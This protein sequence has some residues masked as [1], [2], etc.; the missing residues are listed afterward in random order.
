MLVCGLATVLSE[1]RRIPASAWEKLRYLPVFPIFMLTY[2]PIAVTA[3][4]RKVEWRPIRHTAEPE[5]RR[6]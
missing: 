4:F 2:L 6:V 5:V 1:W 3:L